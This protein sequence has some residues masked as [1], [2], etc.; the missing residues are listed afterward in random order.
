MSAG[1]TCSVQASCIGLAEL[2]LERVLNP[3]YTT[4]QSGYGK[5]V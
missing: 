2:V 1:V 3:F 5:S 4:K